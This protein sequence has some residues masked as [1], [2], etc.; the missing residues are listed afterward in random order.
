MKHL[1]TFN[2]HYGPIYDIGDKYERISP[3]GPGVAGMGRKFNSFTI[4]DDTPT[5]YKIRGKIVSGID[6][7]RKIHKKDFNEFMKNFKR[8]LHIGKD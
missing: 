5:H 7:T 8:V 6:D 3:I 2:E 1:S 4:V